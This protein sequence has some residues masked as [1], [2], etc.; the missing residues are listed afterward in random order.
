MPIAVDFAKKLAVVT[1]GGRGIGLAI[2]TAL[3]RGESGRGTEAVFGRRGARVEGV[4]RAGRW[5]EGTWEAGK[6]ARG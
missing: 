5:D 1:G 6:L 3:A 2:T 4:I